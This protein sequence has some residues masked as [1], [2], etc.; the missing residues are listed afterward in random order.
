MT[1]PQC[2]KRAFARGSQLG[3]TITC[4]NCLEDIL[5]VATLAESQE[6]VAEPSPITAVKSPP[7]QDLKDT[8]PG[9]SSATERPITLT[10]DDLLPESA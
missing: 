5:V 4:E 1:C 7:G 6:P 10:T 2:Q 3:K 8:S 9:G